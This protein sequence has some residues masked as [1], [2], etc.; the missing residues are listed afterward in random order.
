MK[1]QKDYK[2]IIGFWLLVFLVGGLGGLFF[3]K[4]FLPWLAGVKP[5]DKI[6]WLSDFR[7]GTTIINKTEKIYLTQDAAY[8]EAVARVLSAVVD[9]RIERSGKKIAEQSGFISTNDGL[10]MT[11]GPILS[12]TKVFVVRDSKEYEAQIIKQDK[13][14]SLAVLKINE[15]NL[16]VV[17]FGEIN[18][19]KIGETIFLAGAKVT[20]K[21]FSPFIVSGFVGGT[22]P[23]LNVS[24]YNDQ[25]LINGGPL[26]NIRG[27]VF[28]LALVSKNKELQIVASDKISA[29]LK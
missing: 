22:Q 14:N 19:L 28:G 20:E 11:A 29:L 25:D 21:V 26:A 12:G 17:S 7:D 15:T 2:K 10:I 1:K 13:E 24:F 9:V 8:Q 5:F 23:T 3:V 18:S 4:G 27:E 6:G 16:P